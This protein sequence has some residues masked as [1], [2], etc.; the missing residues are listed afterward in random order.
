MIKPRQPPRYT[1]SFGECVPFLNVA[2]KSV[3]TQPK[4]DTGPLV[5]NPCRSVYI[6]HKMAADGRVQHKEIFILA[7]LASDF[8]FILATAN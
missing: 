3:N 7:K 6:A 4:I 5:A 8:Y 1:L 2:K